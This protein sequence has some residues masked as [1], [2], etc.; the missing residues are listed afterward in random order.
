MSQFVNHIEPNIIDDEMVQ[1]AIE[2]KCPEDLGDLARREITNWKVVTELQLSFKS[3]YQNI[4]I[5]C[6]FFCWK[7]IE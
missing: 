2:E 5:F 4:Y 6:L 7:V 3:E 1:K